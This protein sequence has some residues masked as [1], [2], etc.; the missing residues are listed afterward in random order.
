M[1]LSKGRKRLIKY[2]RDNFRNEVKCLEKHN[3]HCG[4]RFYS[5][6]LVSDKLSEGKTIGKALKELAEEDFN[7]L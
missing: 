7:S 5:D 4:V 2:A 6:K 3:Y 1:E